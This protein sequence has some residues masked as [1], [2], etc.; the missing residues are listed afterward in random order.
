MADAVIS[1]TTVED[2]IISDYHHGRSWIASG[3]RNLSA[4][5]G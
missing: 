1:D 2:V 5:S 4:I 3:E